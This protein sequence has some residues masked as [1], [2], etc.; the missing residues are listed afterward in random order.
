MTPVE[1]MRATDAIGTVG[2]AFYFHP[3]TLARGKA[4]GLDG[5]RF[6]IL[7]RG[8]VLGDVEPA[9]VHG[10]FGYFH[11]GLIAKMWTTAAERV[12]PR[13][14]A[15]MYHQCAHELGRSALAEVDG[16]DGFVDAAS[17]IIGSV[18][19]ASLPLFTA[20]RAEPVP[21]DAPAA[22][23]HQA[24]VLREL[25][26]SVHLLALVAQGLDSAT[27]HAIKRP[28]DVTV[29]GYET[30]PDVTDDDRA[31]W[32]RADDMTDELLTP[33]YASLSDAQADA[34]VAG[35][36]AIAAALGV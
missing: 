33:A 26:G 1:I 25:R 29:F 18:E 24:M 34:L 8:G 36:A 17:Q 31:T 11:P 14:A 4:A 21:E 5:F 30:A 16:L 32:Q 12:A 10:A 15:R 19:G 20:M 6:Y 3:D 13:E 7:G 27:A 9:V 2:A 23:I 35:T 28:D 22:A